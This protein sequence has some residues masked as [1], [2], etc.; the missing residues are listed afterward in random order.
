LLNHKLIGDYVFDRCKIF[1]RYAKSWMLIDILAGLPCGLLKYIGQFKKGSFFNDVENFKTL[2]FSYLPRFYMIMLA[3]KLSRIRF[4][5]PGLVKL[6]KKFKLGI[7][8]LNLAMTV[9]LMTLIL[10][11]IACLWGA[12]SL[13]HVQQH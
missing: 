4:A 5:K 12:A 6:L 2:N 8:H 1:K 3:F 11:L 10:H 7:D 13:F 9:W